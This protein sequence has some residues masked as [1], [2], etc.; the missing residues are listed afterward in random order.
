MHWVGLI[1]DGFVVKIESWTLGK[2]TGGIVAGKGAAESSGVGR[3]PVGL[4]E[5]FVVL[6][7]QEMPHIV[8]LL[9]MCG[10]RES[11]AV[12]IILRRRRRSFDI[13]VTERDVDLAR[14]I[15]EAARED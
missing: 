10:R 12:M 7:V 9:S 5:I 15:A 1:G 6:D 8:I 14:E 13:L 4:V 3:A 2:G 11:V